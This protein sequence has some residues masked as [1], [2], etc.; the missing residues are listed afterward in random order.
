MYAK[1]IKD[2]KKKTR[3]SAG[4]FRDLAELGALMAVPTWK[5]RKLRKLNDK[6]SK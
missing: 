4:L 2:M 3:T 5:L 1:I 6:N